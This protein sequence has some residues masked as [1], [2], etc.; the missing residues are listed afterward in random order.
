ML[1]NNEKCCREDLKK[2]SRL[3]SKETSEPGWKLGSFLQFIFHLDDISFARNY[4]YLKYSHG[5]QIFNHAQ[6][7]LNSQ[8]H[9]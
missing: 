8:I 1:R 6:S 9:S 4:E 5:G 2:E 3:S 7:E